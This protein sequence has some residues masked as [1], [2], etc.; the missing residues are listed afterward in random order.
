MRHTSA[1]LIKFLLT[2]ITL[3]L[4]LGLFYRVSYT[5]VLLTTVVLTIAGYLADVYLLPRIGNVFST[6]TDLLLS[7][8]VIWLIG[9]YFFDTDI[10]TYYYKRDA[11]PLFE[12]STIGAIAIS[13]AEWFFHRYLQRDT[14]VKETNP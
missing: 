3:Y 5:D 8:T 6:L 11:M 10:G 13:V 7:F 14:D 9:T 2:G 4:I 1:L 12:A